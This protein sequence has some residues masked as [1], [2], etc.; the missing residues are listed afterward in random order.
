M[1]CRDVTFI[2]YDGLFTA[3]LLFVIVE[4]AQSL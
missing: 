4:G 3:V 1:D 2:Y